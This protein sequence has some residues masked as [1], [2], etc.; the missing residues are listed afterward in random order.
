MFIFFLI[1]TLLQPIVLI[2]DINKNDLRSSAVVESINRDFDNNKKNIEEIISFQKEQKLEIN[3]LD[4]LEIE[5]SNLSKIRDKKIEQFLASNTK[6]RFNSA[7]IIIRN[8]F[9][10]LLWAFVFYKLYIN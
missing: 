3:E 7:K 9:L 4:K 1:S 6:I 5:I 8:I 10:G 2:F